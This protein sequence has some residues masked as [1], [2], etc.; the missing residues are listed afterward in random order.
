MSPLLF[1]T[2]FKMGVI[3]TLSET[4]EFVIRITSN[5]IDWPIHS[6]SFT[7]ENNPSDDY[8]MIVNND[9]IG[10]KWPMTGLNEFRLPIKYKNRQHASGSL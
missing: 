7:W 10:Y 6:Y 2:R 8:T 9:I 5:Y 4:F 1:K 3:Q